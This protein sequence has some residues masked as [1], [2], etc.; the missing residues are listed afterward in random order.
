[1]KILHLL[2]HAH[3]EAKFV[4]SDKERHLDE[5]GREEALKAGQ[6]FKELAILPAFILASPSNRTMETALI[7]AGAIGYDPNKIA[8]N[9]NIY[10][11]DC[12][13]LLDICRGLDNNFPS[14]MVV[15]HNPAISE[16][17][18]GFLQNIF[19]NM[20]TASLVSLGFKINSWH[21]LNWRKAELLRQIG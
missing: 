18:Q 12:D 9:Q 16:M 17:A 10:H 14:I 8:V 2:R 20:K 5:E 3:A 11:S 19:I 6:K 15:G 7:I 21:E 4:V 1:M 13:S